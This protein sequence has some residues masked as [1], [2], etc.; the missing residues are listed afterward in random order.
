MLEINHLGL[1]WVSK[2][3]TSQKTSFSGWESNCSS[4]CSR[5]HGAVASCSP[6][7][8]LL[9]QDPRGDSQSRRGGWRAARVSWGRAGCCA[10]TPRLQMTDCKRC[11]IKRPDKT[12]H[13][14]PDSSQLGMRRSHLPPVVSDF[15]HFSA[16][17]NSYPDQRGAEAGTASIPLS[18]AGEQ[19]KV[20][21]FCWRLSRVTLVPPLACSSPALRSAWDRVPFP[22]SSPPCFGGGG[23]LVCCGG[24]L[25]SVS[26]L[27]S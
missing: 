4:K 23:C 9:R 1:F 22:Y 13:A 24:F 2:A 18:K 16:A 17:D 19:P 27:C 14:E 7:E 20:L 12:W 26:L 25:K 3:T 6:S 21:G 10:G 15:S 5:L 8:A 11:R